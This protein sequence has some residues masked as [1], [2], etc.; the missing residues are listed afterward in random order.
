MEKFSSNLEYSR[1]MKKGAVSKLKKNTVIPPKVGHVRMELLGMLQSVE[2]YRFQFLQIASFPRDDDFRDS[3][4][5]NKRGKLK[6]IINSFGDY[7]LASV[8]IGRVYPGTLT[9]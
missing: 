2:I 8:D 4:T 6:C 1:G 5:K 3:P 7:S 9:T